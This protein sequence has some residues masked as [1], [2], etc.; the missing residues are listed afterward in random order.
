MPAKFLVLMILLLSFVE[1]LYLTAQELAVVRG[2]K[3]ERPSPS[4]LASARGVDA[5]ATPS[6]T[7][8]QLE[9]IIDRMIAREH[10]QIKTIE[11]YAPIIETY[12]QEVKPDKQLGIVPKTDI[13]FLGQAD[14][15]RRLK[16][17]S[18]IKH[19]KRSSLWWSHNPAGFLQMI[20]V[21]R[22]ELDK[23]HYK[24]A[25]RRQ[26]FSGEVRCY[27]FDVAPAAKARGARF[28]GRIW[29]EDQDFTI[30]H[31]NGNYTP[32]VRFSFRSF[33]DEY[34]LHFDSWRTTSNRACGFRAVSTARSSAGR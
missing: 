1:R 3:L 30:V 7:A 11:R 10:E 25:Y 32:A 24:F 27:V 8:L 5:D 12:I 28:A 22:G 15:R 26:E 29:V 19:G 18:S 21:D 4:R 2:A 6:P 9:E 16:V 17:T 31:F 14:F 23:A 13:Y 33:E 34:D 20:Y